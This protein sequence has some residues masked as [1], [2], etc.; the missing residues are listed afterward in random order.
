LQA[1]ATIKEIGDAVAAPLHH[2]LFNALADSFTMKFADEQSYVRSRRYVQVFKQVFLRKAEHHQR[3][4][5]RKEGMLR[6]AM[7]AGGRRT[8]IRRP[9]SG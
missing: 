9:V 4:G 1:K 2:P 3:I 7:G 6:G 5:R 8:A